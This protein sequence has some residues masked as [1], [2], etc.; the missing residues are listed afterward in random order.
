MIGGTEY[1]TATNDATDPEA[2]FAIDNHL[3]PFPLDTLQPLPAKDLYDLSRKMTPNIAF[4]LPRNS[5]PNEIA[6]WADETPIDPDNLEVGGKEF[7]EI[8]ELWM[9][10]SKENP[11]KSG[12]AA[13]A[14]NRR[15]VGKRGADG[16]LKALN[17]YF[18]GL[19]GAGEP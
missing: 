10:R 12:G 7:V 9:G 1:L 2:S 17:A 11:F 15:S 5:S 8:E 18:G 3:P 4:F 19:A 6:L 14:K 16:K 13:G